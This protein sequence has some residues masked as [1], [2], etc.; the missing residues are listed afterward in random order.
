M[1]DHPSS[2]DSGAADLRLLTLLADQP[3][4]SQRKLSSRL[5]WSI[6][7]THYLIRALLEKGLIKVRHFQQSNTKSAY[8]YVLTP[9]GA[10]HKVHLTRLFLARKEQEFEHLQLEI[11][12]LRAALRHASTGAT[13]PVGDD[14]QPPSTAAAPQNHIRR[15]L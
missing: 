7:K 8:A 10:M 12:S 3:A 15:E 4:V 11:E 5:G 6:G 9:Q 1:L 2:P 14:V 13:T